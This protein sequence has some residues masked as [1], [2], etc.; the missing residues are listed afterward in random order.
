MLPNRFRALACILS[1]AVP[2]RSPLRLRHARRPTCR[3]TGSFCRS[4]AS[5]VWRSFFQKMNAAMA[6]WANALVCSGLRYGPFGLAKRAVWGCKTAH[7]AERKVPY[8]CLGW[9]GR[10]AGAMPSVIGQRAQ[11]RCALLFRS[12]HRGRADAPRLG[13]RHLPGGGVLCVV[14]VKIA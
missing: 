7:V 12:G 14:C 2:R 8:C 5:A 3:A 1:A 10:H 9:G 11:P 4:G 6:V 13:L